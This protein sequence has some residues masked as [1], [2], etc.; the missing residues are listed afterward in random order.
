MNDPRQ[1]APLEDS[2][3]PLPLLRPADLDATQRTL[4]ARIAGG[5]RARSAALVPVADGEGRLSGPFNALLYAPDLGNAV[6]EVGSRIRYGLSLSDRE[7]ELATLLVAGHGHSGYELAAHRVLAAAAGVTPPEI[8]RAA[9]GEVPEL[10]DPHEREVIEFCA[11]LLTGTPGQEAVRDAV[12]RLGARAVV[13]LVILVG[14]Y[15]LV[16]RLLEVAGVG[17][18]GGGPA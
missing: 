13:E 18:P 15:Q 11:M 14:Y 10:P 2:P 1:P 7:R 17:A 8:G 9:S 16:A 12:S 4:H 6:Q 5:S 3:S